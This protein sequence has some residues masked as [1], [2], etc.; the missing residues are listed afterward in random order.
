MFKLRQI[1]SLSACLSLAGG[2]QAES[3]AEVVRRLKTQPGFEISLY[4]DQ[5]PLAR[6]LAVSDQGTVYSGSKGGQA[7]AF[8]DLDG[9]GRAEKRYV[10][11]RGL[12]MPIGI[13]VHGGD[14]YLSSTDRVLTISDIES[15]LDSP[16]IPKLFAKA[17]PSDGWHGGKVIR[18]GPDGRLY[19]AV[20]VPCN[21]CEK[22]EPYGTITRYENG[23]AVVVARGIRN[24]VGFDWHPGSGELWFTD[25]GRDMM[26][27]EIPPCEVN[28]LAKEG[29]HFGFP[30][31]HGR[32]VADPE[33]GSSLPRG[34]KP[35]PPQWELK[36]HTAPLG[37][38][39][40][41]GGHFPPGY[42]RNIY[43]AQH[44][45]WNRSKKI[46]YQVLRLILKNGKV[47]REE[48]FVWGFLEGQR[49]MGRPVDLVELADGS[50]LISDDEAGAIYRVRWTGAP[51]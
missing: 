48:P 13:D 36:A 50:L 11:A 37:M 17:W 10:V 19:V 3:G 45:S 41:K 33:F 26:G 42:R 28:R 47:V 29:Q 18:F 38:R 39:F 2:S 34:L 32:D 31:R 6:A 1:L 16:P 51:Q 49:A 46:G 4:T 40:Y 7:Y 8:Q 14:L 43:V 27:D 25:N 24:S 21:V 12:K 22:K 35:E 5:A 44:G 30:Y 15:R 23:K 9:D 20:G